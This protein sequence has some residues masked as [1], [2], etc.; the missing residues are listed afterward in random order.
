MKKVEY[1]A[2]DMNADFLAA[3]KERC[4]WIKGVVASVKSKVLMDMLSID[5]LCL[6]SYQ[7]VRCWRLTINQV[8]G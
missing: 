5:D 6:Y 1:V 7:K 3:F 8:M 4:P 2:S